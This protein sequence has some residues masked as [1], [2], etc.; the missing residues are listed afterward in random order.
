MT[1]L[2]GLQIKWNQNHHKTY[3][4]RINR[5]LNFIQLGIYFLVPTYINCIV[6]CSVVWLIW[7]LT[8]HQQLR[9]YGCDKH[10]KDEYMYM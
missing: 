10:K 8:S 1:M 9:S 5:I 2:F 4:L 7:D 6:T 3:T